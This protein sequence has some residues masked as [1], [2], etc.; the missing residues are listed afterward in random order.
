MGNNM[1]RKQIRYFSVSAGLLAAAFS[2]LMNGC[3]K[4]EP[5]ADKG[6]GGCNTLDATSQP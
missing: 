3:Q 4:V 2:G 5:P 1:N 6:K